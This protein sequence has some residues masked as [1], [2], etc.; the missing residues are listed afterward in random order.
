MIVLISASLESALGVPNMERNLDFVP[1]TA[2][3]QPAVPVDLRNTLFSSVEDVQAATLPKPQLP[4][5][6][7]S[8]QKTIGQ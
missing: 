3:P 1:H 8:Y 7:S 6:I 5:V 2:Q 4:A